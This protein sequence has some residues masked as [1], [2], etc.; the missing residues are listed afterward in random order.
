MAGSGSKMQSK[1]SQEVVIPSTS[2]IHA[3]H[4]QSANPAGFLS[5]LF[6]GLTNCNINFSAQQ[7]NINFGAINPGV[8][9]LE[10]FDALVANMPPST[11]Y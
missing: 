1:D 8:E 6:S 2:Q 10:E 9:Q 3:T 5:S 4:S 11:E 7:L